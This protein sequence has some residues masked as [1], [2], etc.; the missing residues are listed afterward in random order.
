M[1]LPQANQQTYH[2]ST[3]FE[4]VTKAKDNY[5]KIEQTMQELVQATKETKAIL[6]EMRK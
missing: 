1:N 4:L 5:E 2:K 3:V 6:R